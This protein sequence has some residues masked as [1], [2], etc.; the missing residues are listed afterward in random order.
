MVKM[1][2]F[3][4]YFSTIKFIKIQQGAFSKSSS[5]LSFNILTI[6]LDTEHNKESHVV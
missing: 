6:V 1:A 2:K 3:I 5:N 4:I